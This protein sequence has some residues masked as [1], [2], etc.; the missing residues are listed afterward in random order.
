MTPILTDERKAAIRDY[1]R[2][3]FIDNPRAD[4]KK[5]LIDPGVSDKDFLT[6]EMIDGILSVGA[7]DP[8]AADKKRHYKRAIRVSRSPETWR[9]LEHYPAYQ[10]SSHG[11]LRSVMR[12]RDTDVL[13]PRFSWHYGKLVTAY[14]ILDKDGVKR[15][16]FVGTLM[17]NAGFIKARQWTKEKASSI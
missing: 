16:R 6:E 2:T 1:L 5:V 14:N 7:K 13:K 11:R 17:I 3:S 4:L 10:I 9:H 8:K 15:S 12:G